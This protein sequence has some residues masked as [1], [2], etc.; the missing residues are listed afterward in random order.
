MLTVSTLSAM[1]GLM[2]V[3]FCAWAKGPEASIMLL[4]LL[5]DDAVIE[6]TFSKVE[7][8]QIKRYRKPRPVGL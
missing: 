7:V 3:K 5:V 1:M 8:S 2:T 4:F 6:L